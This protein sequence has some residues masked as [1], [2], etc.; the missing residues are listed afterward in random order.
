MQNFDPASFDLFGGVK[1]LGRRASSAMTAA[2]RRLRDIYGGTVLT[3]AK[4]LVARNRAN[5]ARLTA[6]VVDR[7]K[8]PTLSVKTRSGKR[9]Y[10][11]PKI[12]RGD[13]S[14]V[15]TLKLFALAQRYPV[16]TADE[17]RRIAFGLKSGASA[18]E[19]IDPRSF[20]FAAPADAMSADGNEVLVELL[21]MLIKAAGQILPELIDLAEPWLRANASTT[22]D[23]VTGEAGEASAPPGGKSSRTKARAHARRNGMISPDDILEAAEQDAPTVPDD[24]KQ[25][26]AG[27]LLEKLK[28]ASPLVLAGAAVGLIVVARKVM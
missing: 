25:S 23:G 6:R 26:M 17:A 16:Q 5:M 27:Q 19:V 20:R 3:Q 24:E 12:K 8:A 15:A 7:M 9:Y 11:D 10:I 28:T 14:T 21:P 2:E 13:S 1:A 4:N 22:P 18:D